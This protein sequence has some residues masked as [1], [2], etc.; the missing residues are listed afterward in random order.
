MFTFALLYT[1]FVRAHTRH[2]FM[3][4]LSIIR[5]LSFNPNM[6][7]TPLFH[8]S[9]LGPAFRPSQ[10]L[11]GSSVS[12]GLAYLSSL[13]AL[14]HHPLVCPSRR[15]GECVQRVSWRQGTP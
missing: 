12:V 15:G 4:N 5:R 13:L 6:L 7:H 14:K 9:D 2:Q 11:K 3:Y 8:I 1:P 10:G